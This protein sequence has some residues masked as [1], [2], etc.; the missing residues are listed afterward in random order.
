MSWSSSHNSKIRN[1]KSKIV[2]ERGFRSGTNYLCLSAKIC[3]PKTIILKVI[4]S[5]GQ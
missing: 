1:L 3:V 2:P 4:V 5:N